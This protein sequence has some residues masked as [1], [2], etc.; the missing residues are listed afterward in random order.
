MSPA[1]PAS[2]GSHKLFELELRFCI[3]DSALNAVTAQ[4]S[5]PSTSARHQRLQASYF[6]TPQGHLSRAGL[7]W[8]MRREGRLWVQTLKAATVSELARWEHEVE[9][10]AS[11]MDAGLHAGTPVGDQLLDVL[12][13]VQADGS[14]VEPW[15]RTDI[16]RRSRIVRVRGAV[17]EVAFDRGHILAG[18][19][20]LSVSELEFE[21]LAGS[22][23]AMVALAR[24]WSDRWG[25]Q[26]EPRS[27][28]QRGDRLA[29]GQDLAPVQRARRL[30]YDKRASAEQAFAVVM[31]ECLQQ[32]TAN[33][34]ALSA[35]DPAQQVEGVHQLRVG[36]RRFRSACRA[37]RAWVEPPPES[38]TEGL[39]ALFQQLGAARERDVCYRGLSAVLERADLPALVFP[40]M[41]QAP[42]PAALVS[43][44]SVQ[45][46]L[47]D[48]VGWQAS[49]FE[50]QLHGETANVGD[51]GRKASKRLKRWHQRLLDDAQHIRELDEGALHDLR[52]RV[53]RQ[54]Y[55]AECFAPVLGRRWTD[56]YLA[57]L[58]PLQDVLGDLNDLFSARK[59]CRPLSQTQASASFAMGWIA[60]RLATKH[61]EVELAFR[62]FLKTARRGA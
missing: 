55:A 58:A 12:R 40:T 3:P 54:R 21:L 11:T 51:F 59:A 4:M 29:R 13:Q 47:L 33:V 31:S 45:S 53:K 50:I 26:W 28:S 44:P 38:V 19:Q 34:T 60:A 46:S 57:E 39:T 6:D 56:D 62:K 16:Q 2:K 8:R 25:L 9:R 10:D 23:E 41:E 22:A 52:K 18:T 7:A 48:W 37:F 32:I 14:A 5:R 42:D 20:K 27:K 30:I 35:G 1:D 49:R 17:V 24:R 61:D 43:S 36:I 15:Y